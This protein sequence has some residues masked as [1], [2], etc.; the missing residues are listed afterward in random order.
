[1]DLDVT[2]MY[3]HMIDYS[4]VRRK[5]E[6]YLMRVLNKKYW[7]HHVQVGSNAGE[8]E[9]WCYENF[10]SSEWRNVGT[11]FAFKKGADATAFALKW[12]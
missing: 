12:T 5:N 6:E 8:V 3:P 11:Y 2:S 1:M 7:P 4:N 10:K 9:R